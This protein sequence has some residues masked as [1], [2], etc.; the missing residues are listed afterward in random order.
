MT[1]HFW[2]FIAGVATLLT[3]QWISMIPFFRRHR[4]VT[5]LLNRAKMYQ[6][7]GKAFSDVGDDVNAMEA[8]K[9]CRNLLAQ[10]EELNNWNK[11]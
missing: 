7:R 11:K 6:L 3:I 10:V 9:E 8:W 1:F 2:S 4:V 5:A